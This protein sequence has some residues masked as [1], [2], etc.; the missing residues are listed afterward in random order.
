ME[1]NNSSSISIKTAGGSKLKIK[2]TAVSFFISE[3]QLFL[4]SAK[5]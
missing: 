5:T 4:N 1:K 3:I 2:F